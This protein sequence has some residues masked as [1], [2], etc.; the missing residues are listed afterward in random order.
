MIKEQTILKKDTTE[1]WNKAKNFIPKEGEFIYYSDIN[2]YKIGNGETYL[3]DL[4]FIH[5]YKYTFDNGTLIIE[6]G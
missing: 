4:P 2:N 3:Q 6:G 1:N 5:N